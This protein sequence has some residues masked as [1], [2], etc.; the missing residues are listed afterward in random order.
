MLVLGLAGQARSG[1]DTVAAYLAKK[2]GFIPFS[3]S[4]ALYTEVAEAYGLRDDVPYR[5]DAPH[6]SERDMLRS[7]AHKEVP[8]ERLA[9]KNCDYS[10]F[11][12]LAADLLDPALNLGGEAVFHAPLSPRQVL[13]WWGTEFRRAQDPD[14]WL[15]QATAWLNRVRDGVDYPEHRPQ[16]FVN[17][18]V[19]FPNEQ[20]WVHA[21]G[22][23]VWHLRRD[24]LPGVNAHESETPLEVLEGERE[25]W[26]NDTVARL[27]QGIDLL[28]STNARFV[29]VEPM[30]A[31][32]AGV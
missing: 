12:C 6:I 22:G 10:P 16:F 24:G 1:K 20:E 25:I 19:R 31:H 29:R 13:Q 17:T 15:K 14:Y 28:L 23:N 8:T 27:H 5:E 9:L 18:S 2:Y 7:R 30:E 21:Q 26:N 32:D 3:F 4:D 11:Y